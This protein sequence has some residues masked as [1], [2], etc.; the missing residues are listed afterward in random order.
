M[1]N[2][3]E[4]IES[5]T[6]GSGGA[7]SITIGS[8]GTIPQTYTDLVVVSSLRITSSSP[9]AEIARCILKVNSITTGYNNRLVYGLAG[10]AASDSTNDYI[11]YF[12]ATA[13]GAAS[14]TF[15]SNSIY[16]PNYAGSGNKAFSVEAASEGNSSSQGILTLSAGSLSNT[17]A[18]TSLTISPA[19]AYTFAQYS[20]VYLYGVKNA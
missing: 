10:S 18:I 13:N 6:V 17:A 7:A 2:T 20:T 8:G 15:S 9:S 4:L 5:A 16:I 11:T 1:A 3:F 19:E 12:Y 14:G